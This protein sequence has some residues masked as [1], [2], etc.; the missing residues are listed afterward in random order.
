MPLNDERPA[1]S[2]SED[3]GSDGEGEGGSAGRCDSLTSASDTDLSR[4]SF[5][6]SCSSKQSTPSSSPPK[7]VTLDDMMASAKDLSNL[8]LAHEII[9]NQDFHV[10]PPKLAQNSLEKLVRDTVHR[11]YWDLL[12]LELSSSPPEFSCPS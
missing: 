5:T 3:Q 10:E 11:A 4:E 1:S 7:N 2:G 9:V 12:A 8:T 6:S